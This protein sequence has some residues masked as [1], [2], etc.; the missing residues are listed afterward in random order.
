M[1]HKVNEIKVSYIETATENVTKEIASSE[2][3]SELFYQLWDKDTIALRE[4]FKVILLNNAN[5][6]KG[7]Y[8]LS[9]GGITATMVDIRILFAVVIKSLTVGIIIGH[10][11]PSGVLKPST[12]DIKLTRK[13]QEA[14]NLLDVKLLDHLIITPKGSYYSFADEGLL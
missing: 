6:V 4:C 13:I 1:R 9:Q 7:I 12:S 14:A 11:H 10:N 5:K 2:D 3:A 8:E